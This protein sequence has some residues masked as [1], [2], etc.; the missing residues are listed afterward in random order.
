MAWPMTA[1]KDLKAPPPPPPQPLLS[2]SGKM[3]CPP[4]QRVLL[5]DLP[6]R[7]KDHGTALLSSL[8]LLCLSKKGQH[9]K[10]C[11]AAWQRQHHDAGYQAVTGDHSQ[12][13]PRR[14][15]VVSMERGSTQ[16]GTRPGGLPTVLFERGYRRAFVL[17][18]YQPV[19]C[20]ANT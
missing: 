15:N 6:C 17:K 7:T 16:S 11:P 13:H 1:E 3:A 2:P 18:S 19:V 4:E 8:S 5:H 9:A 20:T 12:S 14:G 10:R